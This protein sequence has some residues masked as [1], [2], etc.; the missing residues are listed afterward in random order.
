MSTTV[1]ATHLQFTHEL[2]AAWIIALWKAIHGGDPSPEKIAVQAIA[3][4]ATVVAPPAANTASFEAF[5]KQFDHLGATV[6]GPGSAESHVAASADFT[7]RVYCFTFKGTT[8]CTELPNGGPHT[9][10]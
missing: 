2:D 9:Q 10:Q 8:Y 7:R 4:L 5:Q 6:K 3:A 1:T